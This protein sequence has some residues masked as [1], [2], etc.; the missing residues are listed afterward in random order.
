MEATGRTVMAE[1]TRN[2]EGSW[3]KRKAEARKKALDAIRMLQIEDVPVNFTS[4]H[5]RSGLSK[6]YLYNEPE[7][8]KSIEECREQEKNA[9]TVRH[10]GKCSTCGF[11]KQNHYTGSTFNLYFIVSAIIFKVC[12]FTKPFFASMFAFLNTLKHHS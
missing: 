7:I 1:V 3:L 4:V 11:A 8:R 9:S 12:N 6:N 5:K 2:L 10:A